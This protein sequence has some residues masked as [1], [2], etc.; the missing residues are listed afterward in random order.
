MEK[1]TTVHGSHRKLQ[2]IFMDF[3]PDFMDLSGQNN[4][5]QNTHWI[6]NA[7]NAGIVMMNGVIKLW[8]SM[9]TDPKQSRDPLQ[10]WITML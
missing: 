5:E 7:H 4:R 8:G 2:Q 1:I 6:L 10:E 3:L 9:A